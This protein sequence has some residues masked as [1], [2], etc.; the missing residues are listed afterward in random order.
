MNL[1]PTT[2]TP[3]EVFNSTGLVEPTELTLPDKLRRDLKYY[4][5]LGTTAL[6]IGSMAFWN[7]IEE[8]GKYHLYPAT[9]QVSPPIDNT[10]TIIDWNMHGQTRTRIK[11]IRN[12]ARTYNADQITLQ[13]VDTDDAA[14][15]HKRFPSWNVTYVLADTGQ[16]LLQDGYGNVIMSRQKPEDIK[17]KSFPGTTFF[18]S[19]I[20]SF[21]GAVVDTGDLIT[22]TASAAVD[23]VTTSHGAH[24]N[25]SFQDLKDGRQERR[26]AVAITNQVMSYGQLEDIR[27]IDGHISGNSS[28]RV[29]QLGE[30]TRF[31]KDNDVSNRPT[32]VCADFNSPYKDVEEALGKIDFTIA[33]KFGKFAS[34]NDDYCA[35][36]NNKGLD[37]ARVNVLTKPKTD[38][39]PLIASWVLPP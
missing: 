31:I 35:Y 7:H 39:Y 28:V 10:E 22:G 38:H 24:I 1:D 26:A 3:E 6:S 25:T 32:F 12:L 18:Q 9:T 16:H 2:Q 29:R 23:T 15:L 11:Q 17:A 13:E 8:S 4:I 30:F 27:V 14:L 21:T 34:F 5:A 19:L 37:N 20:R 33:P 36:S